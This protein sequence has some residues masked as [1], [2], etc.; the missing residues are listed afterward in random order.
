MGIPSRVAVFVLAGAGLVH[1]LP[2]ARA[3]DWPQFLGPQRNAVSPEKGLARSWPPEGPRKLWSVPLGGGFAG[4]SVMGGEVFV[5]DRVGTDGSEKD[6]LRCL[7]LQDG[8]ERWSFSYD[9][10][11]NFSIE[12]S[13]TTPTLTEKAVFIVGPLG[14]FHCV[15]RATHQA[16]WGRHL[17]ND[18]GGALPT[19]GV[20]QSPLIYNDLVIVA[21]QGKTA[22]VVACR[23]STGETVW[24]SPP[25]GP[26]SYC[27]PVLARLG[28]VDQVVQISDQG[29]V[30][31]IAAADGKLLWQ[32]KGWNCG[33]PITS[34][35]VI[36]DG[37]LFITGEYGA[38]S[39]MLR[40][41]AQNGA[42]AVEEV[43]RTQEC[44][45]QIH[46]PFLHDGHLY[47]N[48]NGNK[49]R[50]GFVCLDLN[51]QRK[52]FTGNDPNFERGSM[53]FADNLIFA[54]NGRTGALAIIE[55]SPERFRLLAQAPVLKGGQAWAPLAL[56]DGLLLVRDQKELKC[57]DVRAAAL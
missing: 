31:G 38:G 13:R 34:P 10:A 25:L 42:F 48:S 1:M 39:V 44:M 35:L 28:D 22:G 3:G 52:W 43:F 15:D 24:A 7:A 33:I 50:D 6:V 51:G 4:P 8:A 5:L 46:Q 54:V 11:G 19:W 16:V 57:F 41:T 29:T 14:H 45:S 17:L 40:V 21:P 30:S 18:F 20:S 37:R 9:A 32:Y 53:L 49:A 36:G 23:Q 26:L 55:P 56:V 47:A 27:S 12:G 2:A